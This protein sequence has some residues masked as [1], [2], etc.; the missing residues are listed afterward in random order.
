MDRPTDFILHMK[1]VVSEF[2]TGEQQGQSYFL[3][4]TSLEGDLVGANLWGRKSS[5]DHCGNIL[6]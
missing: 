3:T 4:L 6:H 1:E 5:W 2:Y